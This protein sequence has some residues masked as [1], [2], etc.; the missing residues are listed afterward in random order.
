RRPESRIDDPRRTEYEG[1]GEGACLTSRQGAIP[2]A[3]CPQPPGKA[4][5]KVER[6]HRPCRSDDGQPGSAGALQDDSGLVHVRIC[7]DV[8]AEH[9]PGRE[10]DD[11][12][13]DRPGIV[14]EPAQELHRPNP[15]PTIPSGLWDFETDFETRLRLR[16]RPGL[17]NPWLCC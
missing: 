7:G 2:D 13:I 17:G 8:S 4:D 16:L 6:E 14:H 11:D 15:G 1:G 9:E 3:A 10:D 5:E 12:R